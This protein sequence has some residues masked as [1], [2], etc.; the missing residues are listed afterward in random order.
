[1]SYELKW[2]ISAGAVHYTC[3][4]GFT[5]IVFVWNRYEKYILI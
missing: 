5:G 1:M 3:A 2:L 4:D